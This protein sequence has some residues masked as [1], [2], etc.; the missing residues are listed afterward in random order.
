MKG[1][2][3]RKNIQHEDAALKVTMWFFAEELL[4]CFGITEKV[5][6]FAP[7]ESVSFHIS[8][9]Y[10]DFNFIMEDGSWKHFEF[11]SKNEGKQGL[12]RFRSYEAVTSYQNDVPVTTY[13]LYSG[14]IKNPMTELTEGVNTYSVIPIIM[15]DRNADSILEEFRQKI[16]CG[17]MLTRHELAI[18]TLCPL[19]GGE[20]GQK[21]R[22][23]SAFSILQNTK[24][25]KI[26]ED[27]QKI[28][29]VIYAMA[30]KFL[31][32]ADMEDVKEAVRM[33]RLGQLLLEEG[34]EKGMKEGIKTGEQEAKL[35]NARNLLDILDEKMIAERIG[36]PLETV[37]KL[38]KEKDR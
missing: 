12:R 22:I 24:D 8:K 2:K 5:A 36:L 17:E 9:Q 1:K 32:F 21:E 10:Q 20:M 31:D 26:K 4:P 28:E 16:K 6:G 29:A 34:I 15:R 35:N 7:T 33:T 11:Q 27:I 37:R 30:D 23:L 18:L 25:E 14:K 13:V 19:M 38:K 3:V